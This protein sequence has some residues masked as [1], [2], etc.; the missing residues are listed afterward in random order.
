MFLCTSVLTIRFE[1]P[2]YTFNEE[3]GIAEV[4]LI[5]DV[6]TSGSIT[7]NDITTSDISTTGEYEIIAQ[8]LGYKVA[9]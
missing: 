7:I 6:M 5:K 4:C 9:F 2:T 8:L 1:R 3:L